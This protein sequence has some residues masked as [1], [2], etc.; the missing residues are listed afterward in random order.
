MNRLG[1]KRSIP[2]THH[3]LIGAL[4]LLAASL[5]VRAVDGVTEINQAIALSG[6]VTPSD[7]A[8]FPVT[9]D[10]GGSYRLTGNL[11]V[12]NENTTAIAISVEGVTLDL[13]GF[14]ISGPSNQSGPSGTG[15]GVYASA[16]DVSVVN[17]IVRGMG[18]TGVIIDA[19]SRAENLHL[20]YNLTG[21]IAGFDSLIVGVNASR[22][23]QN[24]MYVAGDST[25]TRSIA[26]EN[27]QDGIYAG[28]RSNI[29]NNTAN[30]NDRCGIAASADSLVLNN[31][32]SRNISHGLSLSAGTGYAQNIV[33]E[34]NG[35]NNNLQVSNGGIQIGTNIC[36]GNTS[37]P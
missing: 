2:L 35:G 33:N 8:G 10:Q 31:G 9:I 5:P 26:N 22:N 16:G 24:G 6:G 1:Q 13:N 30:D 11:A 37:C 23:R 12:P 19:R 34:N 36:G 32:V 27:I 29:T 4:A 25:I 17:G 3:L 28:S 14:S 15:V 18:S 21:I 20:Y 7:A